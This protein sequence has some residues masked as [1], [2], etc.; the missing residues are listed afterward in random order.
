MLGAKSA[1]AEECF[2]ENY[3]GAGYGINEN[4]SNRLP[5]NWREFNRQFIPIFLAG[6][7]G[8][9][10]IAAGLA[11]GMVW[12]VAKGI[13][14][15]DYVLSPDGSGRYR[16]GEVVGDYCYTEGASLPHR[17]PMRW[18]PVVIDLSD[19]SESLRKSLLS[20]GTVC[21]LG[22]S[23]HSAE[24]EKLITG[25]G[26]PVIVSM[27]EMVEDAGAFAMERHLEDFLVQNWAQTELG[28]KYDIYEEE[29][30]QAGQQ[31]LTD[32][33]PL[34]ILA[35][36]HDKKELLVIELKKG[37]ASDAVV[38]QTLRYM[39][40]VRDELADAGQSVKG[41]IIASEDDQRIRRA[42][43]MIPSVDFYRYQI[44]FKLVKS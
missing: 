21:N 12:T 10:K 7:P 29:G 18:L 16:V 23:N 22:K 39:G 15:G 26:A 8:K 6:H 28:R 14:I 24:L 4:L 40:Y 11:C 35:V 13:Q 19:V 32:T 31:Y 30:E 41:I 17:R 37:R 27:D 3:I 20:R 43:S 1:L 34:D 36:S 38:G 44:S 5:D 42:L 9:S 2:T 33:G 25:T